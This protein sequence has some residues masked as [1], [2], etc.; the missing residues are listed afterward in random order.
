MKVKDLLQYINLLLN[1]F[2]ECFKFLEADTQS[3]DPDCPVLFTLCRLIHF[4]MF[5]N[6]LLLARKLP[7]SSLQNHWPATFS[8]THSSHTQNALH[9]FWGVMTYTQ[10]FRTW[11]TNDLGTPPDLVSISLETN[12]QFF[13][14]TMTSNCGNAH[15]L[16]Q[17]TQHPHFL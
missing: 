8:E 3:A 16:V 11:L 9:I 17:F 13:Y 14:N 12:H 5:S 7:F 6:C 15:S 1:N 10:I 2:L 4:L